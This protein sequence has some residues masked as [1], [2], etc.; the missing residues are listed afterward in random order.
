MEDDEEVAEAAVED[1]DELELDDVTEAAV[2]EEEDEDEEFA[3]VALATVEEELLE[4]FD[5]ED[6]LSSKFA[7]SLRSS[8][9]ITRN[10]CW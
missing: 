4:E 3:E 8:I 10:T 5:D 7:P 1:E 6:E 9:A 2:D